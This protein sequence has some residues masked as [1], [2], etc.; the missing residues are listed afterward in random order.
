[1]SRF[2]SHFIWVNFHVGDIWFAYDSQFGQLF[3]WSFFR[4][5]AL[6]FMFQLL[7]IYMCFRKIVDVGSS[8]EIVQA[9]SAQVGPFTVIGDNSKIGDNTKITN[10]IIGHGCSIG[11]N[12]KIEG[13]YIWDNVTIEDGCKLSHAIVCDGVVIKSG[14]E[15]EP[16]VIL[17]F[18][19]LFLLFGY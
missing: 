18:K 8:S 14:A 9:R 11:S 10:S 19:V 1:M 13:S 16:G 4:V 2:D 3:L 5:V 17:S 15:L 7:R 12:V 6:P